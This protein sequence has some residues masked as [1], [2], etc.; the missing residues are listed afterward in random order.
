MEVMNKTGVVSVRKVARLPVSGR[1]ILLALILSQ[2]LTLTASAQE[3]AAPNFEVQGV[4]GP[5]LANVQAFLGLLNAE[6]E[7]LEDSIMYRH[8]EQSAQ[9]EIE[10]AMEPFG[11]YHPTVEIRAGSD[12]TPTQIIVEKGRPTLIT[13]ISIEFENHDFDSSRIDE[14]TRH[15]GL[16]IEQRFNHTTYEDGKKEIAASLSGMGRLKAKLTENRVFPM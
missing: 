13:S 10:Q 16:D 8:L 14:L 1:F 2:L 11:Y 9:E 12:G 4:D 5:E 3:D 15:L 7:D 6:P